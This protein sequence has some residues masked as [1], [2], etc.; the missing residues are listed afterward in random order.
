MVQPIWVDLKM[1]F[2]GSQQIK[3][4]AKEVAGKYNKKEQFYQV[5]LGGVFFPNVAFDF[6]ALNF[7]F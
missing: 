1:L 3:P 6:D 7:V 5:H 2:V 4:A